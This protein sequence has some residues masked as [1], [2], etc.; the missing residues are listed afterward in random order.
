[1]ELGFN[2]VA[3]FPL[4][5]YIGWL[6][7]S[8]KQRDELLSSEEHREIFVFFVTFSPEPVL[9]EISS[10]YESWLKG[11]RELRFMFVVSSVST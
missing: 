7:P 4:T 3:K 10:G 5:L 8:A 6:T 11:E 2:P 9:G 1:M